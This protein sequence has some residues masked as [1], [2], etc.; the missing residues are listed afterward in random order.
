MV[1]ISH[2]AHMQD[3]PFK[4]WLGL[5]KQSVCICIIKTFVQGNCM[6]IEYF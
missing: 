4:I 2:V 6:N 1:N 3:L 5:F